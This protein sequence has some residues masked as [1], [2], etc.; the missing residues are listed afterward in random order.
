MD[1]VWDMGTVAKRPV[2]I[3][4]G[5]LY[6]P[7]AFD[8]KGGIVIALWAIRALRALNCMPARRI[9]LLLTSDE[10]T[11]S[12]TSRPIIEME[13]LQHDAV[14]VL[15]PAQP[16][17]AALKTWRGCERVWEHATASPPA[18]RHTTRASTRSKNSRTK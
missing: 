12:K 4:D 6:G 2:Y 3:Q 11:G 13:A 17:N 5:L 15:E 1:T 8:M 7:G 18:V 14:F 9:T 16:P 10:E